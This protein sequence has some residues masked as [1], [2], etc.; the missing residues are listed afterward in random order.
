MHSSAGPLQV[1]RTWSILR[2]TSLSGEFRKISR[3]VCPRLWPRELRLAFFPGSRILEISRAQL[4]ECSSNLFGH[5]KFR[6]R[7]RSVPRNFSSCRC[8]LRESS[9]IPA[10]CAPEIRFAGRKFTRR[11]FA[12]LDRVLGNRIFGL[13]TVL[14]TTSGPVKISRDEKYGGQKDP[15]GGNYGPKSIKS[16]A[17]ET[18]LKAR[19]IPRH[20][21]A[22]C[23]SPTLAPP[24]RP[25]S[26]PFLAG[27]LC[28]QSKASRTRA[29]ERT[30]SSPFPAPSIAGK[31]HC[32]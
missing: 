22:L 18:R 17:L 27:K 28:I 13:R 26:R 16:A 11:N 23:R 6:L 25:P 21:G 10:L 15:F 3:K 12:A 24:A 14:P 29:L 31:S 9:K 2:L 8:T 20:T 19:A 4:R 5:W 32:Q 7:R 1:S 30:T